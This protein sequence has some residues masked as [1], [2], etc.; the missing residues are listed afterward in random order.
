MAEPEE[1]QESAKL[2][3]KAL[4]LAHTYGFK[5]GRCFRGNLPDASGQQHCRVCHATSVV[6]MEN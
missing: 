3:F 2:L 6:R 4:P 1:K 5:C